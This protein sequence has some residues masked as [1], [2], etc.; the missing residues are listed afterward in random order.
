M[1]MSILYHIQRQTDQT[2]MERETREKR[3]GKEHVCHEGNNDRLIR[4]RCMTRVT[5]TLNAVCVFVL[6]MDDTGRG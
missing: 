1:I 4:S 6:C 5:P 3:E 2:Q